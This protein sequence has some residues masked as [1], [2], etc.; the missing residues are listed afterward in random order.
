MLRGEELFA[1]KRMNLS[2][3]VLK[4]IGLYTFQPSWVQEKQVARFINR[5]EHIPMTS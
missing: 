3:Q 1:T 4:V 2:S 5:Y